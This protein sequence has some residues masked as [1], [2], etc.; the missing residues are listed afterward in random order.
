MSLAFLVP[1]LGRP[2]NVGRLLGAINATTPEAHVVFVA[3]PDDSEEIEEIERHQECS[4]TLYGVLRISL[5]KT[6]G[7]Y[8]KKI[9]L[10]VAETAEPFLFFGADDLEPRTDW[11][12]V[13]RGRLR[14]DVQ[15]V[16]VNDMLRRR[17]EHATHFLV[18]RGYAEQ[19]TID[20]DRGP[21]YEGYAHNFCD[22]EF[23][24]TAKHRGVYAYEQRANVRH[25]HPMVRTAPDDP[26]YQ[27]GRSTF[28]ADRATFRKRESLWT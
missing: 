14:R 11:F 5:L 4:D 18:T 22:D 10:A 28:E 7:N 1:V 16:G 27:K 25:R 3:D 9:N 20:G 6:A 12:D 13:A 17:R 19:P 15:V 21:I 8:A 26:T 23:I 2:Q 24:A